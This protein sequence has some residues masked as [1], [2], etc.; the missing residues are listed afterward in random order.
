MIVTPNNIKECHVDTIDAVYK[1]DYYLHLLPDWEPETTQDII[2]YW[3]RFWM[4]LPDSKSIHRH[5]FYQI[6]DI[7]ECRYDEQFYEETV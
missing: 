7:A 2:D 3:N 1:S 5:P 6:C 4:N